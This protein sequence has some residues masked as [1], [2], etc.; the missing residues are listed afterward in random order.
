M[1]ADCRPSPPCAED[2]FGLALRAFG[3][4]LRAA[5][6]LWRLDCAHAAPGGGAGR[7]P[8]KT[9]AG[10]SAKSVFAVQPDQL[11]LNPDPV[12][13]QDADFIG[14]IGGLERNRGAAAAETLQ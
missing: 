7:R 8:V 4:T 2:V 6:K 9:G 1:P 12:R 14:G 13:R 10:R 5:A 11:A 3:P